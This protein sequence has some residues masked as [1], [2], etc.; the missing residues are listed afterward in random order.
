MLQKIAHAVETF[1]V[2]ALFDV[3][4]GSPVKG[5]S[6]LETD[7]VIEQSLCGGKGGRRGLVTDLKG[8]L[9]CSVQGGAALDDFIDEADV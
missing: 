8:K 7:A 6:P 3:G 5:F 9:P 1:G 4:L 2:A